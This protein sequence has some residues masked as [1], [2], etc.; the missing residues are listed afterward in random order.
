MM[1]QSMIQ[2]IFKLQAKVKSI[3]VIDIVC[4]KYLHIYRPVYV[5]IYLDSIA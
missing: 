5:N 2:Y 3:Y 4:Q 1:I